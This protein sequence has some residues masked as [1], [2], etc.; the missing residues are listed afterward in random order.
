MPKNY[1]SDSWNT[2]FPGDV[3][4]RHFVFVDAAVDNYH[5]LIAGLLLNTEL[6]LLHPNEDGVTQISAVLSQYTDVLSIHIISHGSPSSLQ[7][8]NTQLSL[9]TLEHYRPQ[10]QQWRKALAHNAELLLYGCN[11]AAGTRGST[12]IEHLKVLTDAEV[13]ASTTP[14]GTADKG[15]NW[16]LDVATGPIT[17]P[18]AFNA[19]AM[20]TY[21][22]VLFDPIVPLTCGCA[23]CT[24]SY[25]LDQTLNSWRG[26]SSNQ[27]KVTQT[28]TVVYTNGPTL[29]TSTVE[30]TI[31]TTPESTTLLF[32]DFS[33]ASG[34]TP[35]EGWTNVLLTG[36]SATDAWRF[37]NPGDRS[38]DDYVDDPF[39]IYDSDFLSNDNT[40]E[41][42]TLV[43]PIFDASSTDTVFLQFDQYY[44]GF[45]AGEYASAIY[46]EASTD[47]VNW[48]VAY[49]SAIEGELTV[50]PT[51]DLTEEL[52]GA[53]TAQV[54]F[55]FDGNWSYA[56]AIDN[57]SIIDYLPPGVTP[58]S[59]LVGVSE[60]NVPDPIDFT[61][62]LQSRP[63]AS[64]TLNF[65]VDNTQLEAIAPLTFT[66]D[67][68]F[69]PQTS[70]VTAVM[71]DSYEGNYQATD[72]K[73]VV[74]SDDPNYD[75]IGVAD[76]PV[77]ITE[78]VI[79]GYE[80]YRTVEKTFADLAAVAEANPD[81]ATWVDIGDSYDK[82]TP[83]GAEGYDIYAL[84]VG[85]KNTK[86]SGE[87]PVLFIES[88][89]HAREYTTAEAVTRFAEQLVA[90]YGVDAD[91]TRL[92][93]YV[94]IRLVPIVNPDGRKFAEQGYLWRKNTNPNPS[95]GQDPA[96]F[97]TYGVDLNRNYA[98]QW[99]TQPGVGASTDPAD[100]TYQ[101]STPFS[102]P[103]SQALRDYLLATF[104]DQKGPDEFDPAPADT[105]G[106]YI[107]V[108]SY[109][110][111]VLYPFGWTEE[112][113]PNQEGLRNL[114]LKFG[115]FTGVDGEAY[116][117]GQ[118][119]GL[120][121][122]TGTTDDWVYST[123]GVASYT[124]ELG[125]TFFQDIESFEDIIAPEII[126][127]FYYGAKAAYRPYQVAAGPDSVDV[128]V[129]LGQVT[130]GTEVTL[131][132]IADATRYD[133]LAPD[134]APDDV[135]IPEPNTIAGA[136]YSIDAPSWIEG[137]ETYELAA[138]DGTFNSSVET[139]TA[140]IDTSDLAPG[141]HTIFVESLDAEGN[142]GVATAVFLDVL[143]APD[144]AKIFDGKN[145][146]ETITG[147]DDDDVIYGRGGPDLV[148]GKSGNDIMVAGNGKDTVKGS[149]GDDL[150]Y[151]GAGSDSLNGSVGD[152]HLYGEGD[153]DRLIGYT[154][155]DVLWGGA[156]DDKLKGGDGKDTY[157]IT[158]G[159][160]TDTINDFKS[161]KDLLGLA[162][163]LSFSQLSITQEGKDTLISF[164]KGTLAILKGVKDTLTMAD[165]VSV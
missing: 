41:S 112:F 140:T 10:L 37:D 161:G 68:W 33:A 58:P 155:D 28:A 35:P 48:Q 159:E 98:S 122:T 157:V 145:R 23:A 134:Y 83:G 25:Y 20:T 126:P 6:F 39:A 49:S 50:S 87:K 1:H 130:A 118:A 107:D 54:R 105:T 133:D 70:T 67:N 45:A 117:V 63:T 165:F 99:G 163:R 114:G 62:A 30:S 14:I 17:S 104:P 81:L 146:G 152:D 27:T 103:E 96:P 108:H 57:I 138:A 22:A 78:D 94:D 160:G 129:D 149:R 38:I 84:E 34:A 3:L 101:G 147:T 164:Q 40:A 5:H 106:V 143:E 119:V 144:D 100:A 91:I 53:E 151:G 11:V 92:L 131:T 123:L 4:N 128:A 51:V 136:R 43:S 36:N 162:G 124:F 115:Y 141:R 95:P 77:Q 79:P 46:V 102:E 132:A 137:T 139:V 29:A 85:S 97:P 19:E 69:I 47:G 64:V 55:R 72:V 18:L 15:G 110:N 31:A 65:V 71:D 86:V 61:F 153:S 120:Y 74:T 148:N 2:R 56:W 21:A 26:S 158:I 125:T 52:A 113:A 12:F 121:P 13:A 142:Y 75:G 9:N 88:S 116:N 89:I 111:L 60:S 44:Y 154:G 156:G 66:P 150:I 16:T 109:G 135:E 8:G 127:A 32:E 59:G 42:V 76:I 7:L 80:S 82:V 90:S 24:L 73:V 93:D